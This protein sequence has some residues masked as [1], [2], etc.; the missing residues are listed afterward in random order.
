VKNQQHRQFSIT[1]NEVQ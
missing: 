1:T